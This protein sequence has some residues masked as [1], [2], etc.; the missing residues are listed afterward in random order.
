MGFPGVRRKCLCRGSWRLSNLDIL[1]A[2]AGVSKIATI[3]DT[4]VEDFDNLF[5]VA[6]Y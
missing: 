3:E 2:N 6:C 5:A 4:T 1:V